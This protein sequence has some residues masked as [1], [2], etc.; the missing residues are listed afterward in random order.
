MTSRNANY[1]P[2]VDG[3]RAVAV[4]VVLLFHLGVGGFRGG[5][6]GVDVFLV[7]S[8]FLIT[9]L[10]RDE[11]AAT[12]SFRFGAFYL[13]RVRRLAPALL[14]ASLATFAAC[15]TAFSPGM[16]ARTAAELVAAV[17]SVSN[18]HFW[19]AADYFDVSAATRPLLHTWS[20]SVEEQFY[21]VWPALLLAL[22]RQSGVGRLPWALLAIGVA[23]LA[24]NPAFA[25]GAPGWMARWLPEAAGDGKST[26]FYLLPFRVFEFTV[27]GWLALALPAPAASGWRAEAACGLGVVAIGAAVAVFDDG[28]LFPSFAGLLPCAGAVLVIRHGAVAR[29][30]GWLASA[31]MV[32][33]GR[34]SYSVYLWHWPVIVVAQY[35]TGPSGPFGVAAAAAASLLLG[36]LSWRFVESP[37]RER[38]LPLWPVAIA[39]VAAIALGLHAAR[40]GWSWRVTPAIAESVAGD[41]AAHHRR[42]Y[43]GAGYRNGPADGAGP[44]DFLLVGDS[45]GKQYAEGLVREVAAARGLRVGL[46]AGTS[47]LHLPGFVRRTAGQDWA[48]LRER[49]LGVIRDRLASAAPQPVV[50]LGQA[51]ITQADRSALVDEQGRLV[52]RAITPDDVVAGLVRLRASCGIHRLVVVGQAPRPPHADLYEELTRPEWSRRIEAA[53]VRTFPCSA[54]VVAWNA[55]LRAGAERTGAYE[56]LDPVE[57]LSEDG[58]CL[59]IDGDGRLVYSDFSDYSHLS[60]AGSRRVMRAFAARLAAIA[61]AR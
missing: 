45:H 42:E 15:A 6:V 28:M 27:G 59:A 48:A 7:I 10:I 60:K 47:C 56:F 35:L 11:I 25:D 40:D 8:G 9:R 21:L 46:E 29:L 3:L 30:G 2:H 53:S 26:V 24:L 49:Q 18:V 50:V 33:L 31:P 36:H 41:P 5:F 20:L 34:I 61:S 38:R 55:A 1:L 14:V 39:A 32:H 57:A 13:R 44:A 23:S 4:A 51:W 17:A 58:A 43:G 22:G 16:L 19:L 37:F 54:E 52:E 12:G